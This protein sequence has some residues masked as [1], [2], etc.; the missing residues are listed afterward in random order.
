MEAIFQHIRKILCVVKS[1]LWHTKSKSCIILLCHIDVFM[2][3]FGCYHFLTCRKLGSI[4]VTEMCK[5]FPVYLRIRHWINQWHEF[6]AW[7]SVWLTNGRWGIFILANLL[8]LFLQFSLVTLAAQKLHTSPLEQIKINSLTPNVHPWCGL[9]LCP[10]GHCR[11]LSILKPDHTVL[12]NV[13][14][15]SEGW[16]VDVNH[17]EI[18]G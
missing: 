17:C 1:K 18:A 7:L 5:Y 9:F 16:E 4:K 10:H 14:Q 6:G 11:L 13:K 2:L 8:S 12:G 15:T 3:S